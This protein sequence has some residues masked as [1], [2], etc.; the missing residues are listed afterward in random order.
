MTQTRFL[1]I[2]LLVGIVSVGV[3]AQ[4]MPP[5]KDIPAIARAAKGAIVTIVMANED[6]PI[7]LGTGFV[8]DTGG[9]IV[10]NYHVIANGNN[11]VVKFSDG[12]ML[13]VDGV[14]ATDK[15]RRPRR[16]QSARG[17]FSNSHA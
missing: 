10:T 15:N 3:A 6:K 1:T 13:V 8:V 5:K 12:K 11:G 16:H 9:V 7:A 14:L 4:S 17:E 2:L